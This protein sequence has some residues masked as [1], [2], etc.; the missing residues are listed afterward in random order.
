MYIGLFDYSSVTVVLPQ[1]SNVLHISSSLTN[2]I[3]ISFLLFCT[4]SGLTF[5]AI[6]PKYGILKV[7]KIA[8]IIMIIGG[9][10]SA[11]ILNPWT[12]I[13][14][15]SVQGLSTAALFIIS[16][17]LI[18]KNVEENYVGTALGIVTAGGFLSSITAPTIGGFLSFYFPPQT[19]FAFSVPFSIICLILLFTL[20]NEWTEDVSIDFIG[21]GFWFLIM[22]LFIYG[23]SYLKTSLGIICLISSILFLVLFILYELNIEPPLY[24]FRLLKNKIYAVNNYSAMMAC[25]VKDGMVF[26]L[27]LYL[28]YSKGLS[29]VET[30]LFISIFAIVMF[31]TS[32]VAGRLS[33]KFDSVRLSNA[34][35]NLM[36]IS[37]FIICLVRYLPTWSIMTSIICLAVGYGLFD[38]P[39]K[40]IILESSKESELSY[41]TAFLSTIRDFGM[42]LPT[43]IFTLSLSMFSNIRYGP[44]YWA[45]SSQFMFDLFF[46]IALSILIFGFYVNKDNE[47]IYKFNFAKL[48]Q[49]VTNTVGSFI[50]TV[51][52]DVV[53]T[54][55]YTVN[56]ISDAPNRVK[57][58]VSDVPDNIS[59]VV[60]DI[61]I[62]KFLKNKKE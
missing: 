23:V 8:V 22:I 35:A 20:K 58:T 4:A 41:V 50:G 46:M 16:Y 34:G 25:F 55:S 43:A 47:V 44:K 7:S 37:T 29:S 53:D 3:S 36:V 48:S 27:T 13:I 14:A 54:V 6:V 28:Q 61:E 45:S 24:N 5:G 11:L 19:I 51:S 38:T 42:L 59:N 12:I 2:W 32:P 31:L 30:G 52:E 18:I 33:D 62:L 57:D 9:L 1:L 26:V 39:N 60:D 10:V 56:E 49:P 40:K 21:T 17:L 15:R